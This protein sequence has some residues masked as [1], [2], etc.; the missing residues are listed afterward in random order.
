MNV[1]PNLS[2]SYYCDISYQHKRSARKLRK[3][4]PLETLR[5]PPLKASINFFA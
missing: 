1:K 4:V 2:L 5:Y 3:V